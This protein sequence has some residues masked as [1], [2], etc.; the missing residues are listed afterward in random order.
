MTAS[1]VSASQAEQSQ[2]WPL[3]T[4][5]AGGDADVYVCFREMNRFA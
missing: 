2:E 4:M 3:S 1:E 5:T